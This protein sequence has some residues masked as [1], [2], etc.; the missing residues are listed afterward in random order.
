MKSKRSILFRLIAIAA[1]AVLTVVLFIVGRGHTVY[2]DN[3][4]IE[5]GGQ[6]YNA[7]YK[8]EVFVNDES[9]A[10][11]S[12]EDRG[13]AA[14]MGQNF[15]MILHITPE[16]DAKKYGKIASIKIPYSKD[17]VIVN[18]PALLEGASED[19]YMEEFIPTAE[20]GADDDEEVVVTDEFAM[21]SEE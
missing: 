12:A 5:S 17:S 3:K 1:L 21:P 11:L 16:K 2:L 15:S 8:V 18:I 9:V 13:M 19:V 6:T 20:T 10:K 14:T 7:Y 4:T